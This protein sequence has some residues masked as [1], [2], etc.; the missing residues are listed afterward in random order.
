MGSSSRMNDKFKVAMMNEFDMKDLVLKKYFPRMEVYENKYEIS[1]CE[2]KYAQDMLNK[3][4]MIDCNPSPTPSCH[5]VVLCR[6]DNFD[7]VDETTYKSIVGS[8]IF[9]TPHKI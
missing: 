2:T 8:F 7:L 3:F 4:D 5:G 6:N 9:L 1:I